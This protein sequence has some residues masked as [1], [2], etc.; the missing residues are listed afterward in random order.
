MIL[1]GPSILTMYY[2]FILF[3]FRFILGLR[4]ASAYCFNMYQLTP[5]PSPTMDSRT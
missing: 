5:F 1:E 2:F 3:L 4:G